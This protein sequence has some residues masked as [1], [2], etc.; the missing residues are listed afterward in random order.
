MIIQP[1]IYK[2]VNLI[3]NKVYIGSSIN[4]ENRL[5]VHF[6]ALEKNRHKNR[7]LQCAFNKF[8]VE[9]FSWKV[10]EFCSLETLL[11]REQFYIDLYKGFEYNLS[12]TAKNTLGTEFSEEAKQKISIA[13]KGRVSS[14]KGKHHSLEAKM[15]N[16]LAHQGKHSSS[17]TEF[18]K[19]QIPWNKGKKLNPLSE[20]HKIKLS[21]ALKG[22]PFTEE[23][24]RKINEALKKRCLLIN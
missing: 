16:S 18:K 21:K 23:H 22:K 13:I 19:G 15:K 4:V 3:D 11:E 1:G 17:K 6:R 14:F 2:I 24:R 8:G 10:M 20:E 9:C 7:H 5:K 12:P